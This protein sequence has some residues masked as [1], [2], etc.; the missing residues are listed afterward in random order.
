M[1]YRN[2]I[3]LTS[4]LYFLGTEE[5]GEERTQVLWFMFLPFHPIHGIHPIQGIPSL[6]FPFMDIPHGGSSSSAMRQCSGLK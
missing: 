2:L 6:L 1:Q 4:S 5:K 3:Y